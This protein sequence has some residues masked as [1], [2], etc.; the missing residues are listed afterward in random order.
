MALPKLQIQSHIF[1]ACDFSG[2]NLKATFKHYTLARA[3]QSA[4]DEVVLLL[5]HGAGLH[6]E[7]WEPFLEDLQRF[8]LESPGDC[9]VVEAWAADCPNHGEGGV[10]N[11]RELYEKPGL[12]TCAD[13]AHSFHCLLDSE[14]WK[15]SA[16]RRLVQVGHSAG[17]IASI[18]A[19][20]HFIKQGKVQPFSEFIIVDM[21][22]KSMPSPA[23]DA[24]ELSS[25]DTLALVEPT[26]RRKDTWKSREEAHANL[27][28]RLP[29]RTWDPRCLS[30]FE[31]HG[32]RSLPVS[33]YPDL[34]EGVTLSC[35]KIQES[36]SYKNLGE[37]RGAASYLPELTKVLPVHIVY[38]E[39]SPFGFQDDEIV[40]CT[41]SKFMRYASA[42]TIPGASHLVVQD[43][44]TALAQH[45]LR[46]LRRENNTLKVGTD[47]VSSI[48][49]L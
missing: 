29:W 10:V 37:A 9:E 27:L 30:L 18:I 23:D 20:R 34:K 28:Q 6:K 2:R 33:Y 16:R 8:Q 22:P 13:F 38:G 24:A 12:I 3:N 49:K 35:H 7:Q 21:I 39:L 14:H 26:R 11:D 41:N 45:V 32:L 19:I 40:R 43:Q 47:A 31:E 44:P 5:A 15:A 25:I 48:S 36:D 17:V 46:L 4:S 42:H 1:D